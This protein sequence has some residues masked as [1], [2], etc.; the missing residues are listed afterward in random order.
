MIHSVTE[1]RDLLSE[2]QNLTKTPEYPEVAKKGAR[3]LKLFEPEGHKSYAATHVRC[4]RW[5]ECGA[6][7]SGT[8]SFGVRRTV[9]ASLIASN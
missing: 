2:A 4:G 6:Q 5:A 8:N 7:A 9:V 3:R 1:T